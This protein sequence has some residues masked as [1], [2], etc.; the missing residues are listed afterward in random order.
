[1]SVLTAPVPFPPRA[2]LLKA[3]ADL[4]K[5][6]RGTPVTVRQAYYRLVAGGV[7]PNHLRSYKNLVAAL[8]V[9]RRQKRIPFNAF[10]DRT[11]GLQRLD[12]GWREDAPLEWL[13]SSLLEGV[14]T[15]ERYS[16]ARWFGQPKRVVVAVEKQAL[17]GQFGA[18]CTKLEVDLAVCRGYASLSFLKEISDALGPGDQDRDGRANVI[19]YFGDL[20]PSGVNIPEVVERDLGPGLFRRE[21]TLERIALTSEQVEDLDLL[22]APVKLRDSRAQGFI[23]AHGS[24]VYELDSIEP[25]RLEQLIRDSIGKHWDPKLAR[26]RDELVSKGREQILAKLDESGIRELIEGMNE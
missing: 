16:V 23:D 6:Y 19:L 5:Q 3:V 17:E 10:E 18:V 2:K 11:R 20:D 26:V 7:I 14:Q 25:E 8:S 1:V 21:F 4:L 12:I 13:S 24:D 9:W 22:P 15:A